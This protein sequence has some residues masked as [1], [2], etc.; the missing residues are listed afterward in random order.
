MN[1]SVGTL[2]GKKAVNPLSSGTQ[3]HHKL[4]K[5]E[6]LCGLYVDLLFLEASYLQKMM[7][8][9]GDGHGRGGGFV[10]GRLRANTRLRKG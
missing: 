6:I 4:D 9:S 1:F 7:G 8:A 3:E 10:L 2:E 5:G